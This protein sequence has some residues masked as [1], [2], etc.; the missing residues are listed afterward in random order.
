M[1]KKS[2]IKTEYRIL[3]KKS[4]NIKLLNVKYQENLQK[5]YP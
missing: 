5:K 1:I 3:N 2:E 4:M